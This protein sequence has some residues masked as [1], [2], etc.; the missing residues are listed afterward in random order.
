MPFGLFSKGSKKKLKKAGKAAKAAKKAVKKQ[1][2]GGRNKERRGAK[3]K[4][5]DE[6]E[7]DPVELKE[8]KEEWTKKK[9]AMCRNLFLAVLLI[10]PSY[11]LLRFVLSA[12]RDTLPR[13]FA[14]LVAGLICCPAIYAAYLALG[15]ARPTGPPPK[16]PFVSLAVVCL[17]VLIMYYTTIENSDTVQHLSAIQ[18]AAVVI[19][20]IV[21]PILFAIREPVSKRC[22]KPA[23]DD[24]E[25]EAGWAEEGDASGGAAAA[26]PP[27]HNA[28]PPQQSAAPPQYWGPPQQAMPPAPPQPWHQPMPPQQPHPQQRPPMLQ[29]PHMQMGYAGAP[30]P[31]PAPA[32]H[33]GAALGTAPWRPPTARPQLHADP[34]AWA[35]PQA[36]GGALRLGP[37]RGGVSARRLG[38]H[39]PRPAAFSG[40]TPAP[41]G[42]HRPHPGAMQHAPAAQ[43]APAQVPV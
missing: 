26:A 33:G 1:K 13:V 8:Q 38:E 36:D 25:G 15:L 22:Q 42:Q 9:P 24:E 37:F 32:L 7:G 17:G 5:G 19:V 14:I 41:A 6:A 12:M 21:C 30:Q 34:A 31:P 3:K 43:L 4:K 40:P 35:H 27:Q 20:L 39:R 29:Q 18:S 2:K 23:E 16:T 11:F 10:L 28:A